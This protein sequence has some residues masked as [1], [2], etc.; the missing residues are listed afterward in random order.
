MSDKQ[1]LALQYADEID[2]DEQF[3]LEEAAAELRRLHAV[4]Q[5]LV[6]ALTLARGRMLDMMQQDDGQA[7]KDAER[8]M[9]QIEAALTLAQGEQ[10]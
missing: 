2:R 3:H 7:Y 9:P 4:N 6:D 5:G 8:A 10:K 1:P